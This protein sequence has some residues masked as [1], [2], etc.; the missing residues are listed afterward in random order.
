M[1]NKK[2]LLFKKINSKMI[3]K[4]Y[5]GWLNDKQTMRF[6]EQRFKKHKFSD[7]KKY[8]SLIEK[9]KSEFLYAIIIPEKRKNIHIG[10]IKIGPI[11]YNHRYAYISY[12]IGNKLYLNKGYGKMIIKDIIKL[13]KKKFYLKKILAGVYSN[14]I[15]STKIL[16]FN[17]FKLEGR[18]TK[19]F[20][21]GNKYIDHLIYGKTL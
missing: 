5:V 3:T 1:K 16:E 4:D 7:V 10:N 11:N 2:N 19:K 12:F 13:A 17:K 14:N 9:S 15:P 20:K 21:F 6:T 8:V 18:I